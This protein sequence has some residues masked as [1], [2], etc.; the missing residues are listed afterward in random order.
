MKSPL[1]PATTTLRGVGSKIPTSTGSVRTVLHTVSKVNPTI[2][3]ISSMGTFANHDVFSDSLK[4]TQITG[5]KDVD[6]IQDS[7]GETVG[8]TFGKGGLLGGVGEAGDKNVL[9]GNV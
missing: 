6:G 7:V 2:L 3:L 4:Q 1:R 8:N 9:K 5:N